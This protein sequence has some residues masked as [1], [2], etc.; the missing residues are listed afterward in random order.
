MKKVCR[1]ALIALILAL[2]VQSVGLAATPASLINGIWY[3]NI[4]ASMDG[5]TMSTTCYIT[6]KDGV[7][8]FRA[9]GK[10]KMLTYAF[11]GSKLV[12]TGSLYG[13]TKTP[14]FNYSLNSRA[15]TLWLSTTS[16]L[17]LLPVGARLQKTS[18][19]V[20]RIVISQPR[21]LLPKNVRIYVN[22]AADYVYLA[23]AD[24]T[25]VGFSTNKASSYF[26][27][28]YAGWMKGYN[29]LYAY[30][31]AL[32]VHGS[33]LVNKAVGQVLD[34]ADKAALSTGYKVRVRA[35]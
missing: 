32:D 12:I 21:V 9:A 29:T 22:G 16:I 34:T 10:T 33:R 7:A 27:I 1:I 35:R 4:K 15:T 13:V 25:V 24:G 8:R 30:A 6:C 20:S 18:P 17:P 19:K 3:G 26:T 28:S 5:G 14:E 31:G 11:S 23:K 2:T